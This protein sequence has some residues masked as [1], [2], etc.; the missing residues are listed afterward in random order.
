MDLQN[1]INLSK[2]FSI[3]N[4]YISIWKIQ[5]QHVKTCLTAVTECDFL[6]EKDDVRKYP[7]KP[8]KRPK[9]WVFGHFKNCYKSYLSE[10]PSLSAKIYTIFICPRQR[11]AVRAKSLIK[12]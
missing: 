4:F 1:L 7:L 5:Q 10:N 12:P 9:N 2:P 6:A 3:E 11:V 8:K